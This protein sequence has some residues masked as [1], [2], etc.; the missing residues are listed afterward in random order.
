MAFTWNS[1]NGQINFFFN[2]ELKSTCY[3]ISSKKEIKTAGTFVLGQSHSKKFQ[4]EKKKNHN[5]TNLETT[6][7]KIFFFDA[8]LAFAG[9]IFNFNI[10]N[11]VLTAN[12]IKEIYKDC[13][14]SFCGTAVQWS[15]FRQ[16]IKGN[17]K[18][19]WSTKLLWNDLSCFNETYQQLSCNQYCN[20]KIGPICREQITKNILW[21][22]RKETEN[23]W[24]KC[25]SKSTDSKF[26]WRYCNTYK[27]S[28]YNSDFSHLQAIA[29]WNE[30]NIE[31]CVQE[32]FF[33]LQENVKIFYTRDNF[34]ESMIFIYLE[35]L[36]Q[37]FIQ[38]IKLDP[39]NKRSIFDINSLID[40]LFY[41]IDA[42]VKFY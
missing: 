6:R 42:Q 10:W 2:G 18:F 22:I 38:N 14:L 12:S 36:Y 9:R 5:Q 29:S 7:D 25:N 34:D 11:N 19:G 30:P 32:S 33:K 1:N 40:T 8:K 20:K 13:K 3:N 35:T 31:N 16:G 24:V 37:F 41:L 4:K 27:K 17:I 26:A 23:A 28:E 39:N 21:P 15:N